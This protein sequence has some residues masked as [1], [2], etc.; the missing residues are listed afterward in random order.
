MAEGSTTELSCGREV[1]R[2]HASDRERF[3]GRE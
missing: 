1:Q 2:E 3:M